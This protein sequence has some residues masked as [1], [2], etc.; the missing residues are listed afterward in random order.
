MPAASPGRSGGQGLNGI[1]AEEREDIRGHALA[2]ARD[3]P[4]EGPALAVPAMLSSGLETRDVSP[5][6]V[7]ERTCLQPHIPSDIP[8]QCGGRRAPEPARLQS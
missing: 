8:A 6:L 4:G 1:S 3:V 5:G 2:A 7:E